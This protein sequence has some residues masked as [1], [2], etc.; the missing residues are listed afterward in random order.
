MDIVELQNAGREN[1][2]VS[3]SACCLHVDSFILL[4]PTYFTKRTGSG[5]GNIKKK[6]TS[7]MLSSFPCLRFLQQFDCILHSRKSI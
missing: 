7:L 1:H 3:K 2:I 4:V 5:I 6:I